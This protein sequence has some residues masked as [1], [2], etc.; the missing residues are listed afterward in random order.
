MKMV[1]RAI[2]V[3]VA[4]LFISVYGAPLKNDTGHAKAALGLTLQLNQPVVRIGDTLVA[5]LLITNISDEPVT[6]VKYGGLYRA[7][8]IQLDVAPH[9]SLEPERQFEKLATGVVLKDDLV[10]LKPKAT[11]STVVKSRIRASERARG[12]VMLDFGD[13]DY[14][15]HCD[16]LYKIRGVFWARPDDSGRFKVM[17]GVV[18]SPVQEFRVIGC[19]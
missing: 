5:R 18:G 12:E 3:V 10:T 1:V 9:R 14:R 6:F 2:A 8:W 13:S 11:F 19:K 4:A 16:Q 17:S 7:F 15:L